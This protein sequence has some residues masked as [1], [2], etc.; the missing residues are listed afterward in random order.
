MEGALLAVLLATT[1]HLR[2]PT[3]HPATMEG[4]MLAQ[5]AT[6][7]LVLTLLERM[8]LLSLRLRDTT[9]T[10]S[11][12]S[13]NKR[14]MVMVSSRGEQHISHDLLVLTPP[15]CSYSGRSQEQQG[16]NNGFPSR[17]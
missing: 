16:Y 1:L 8:P 17:Q 12:N 9:T 13:L 6:T 10:H 4:P 3:L 5:A 2:A 15:S 11:L 14:C 7:L